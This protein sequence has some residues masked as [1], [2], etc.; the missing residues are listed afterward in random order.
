M[1]KVP[2]VLTDGILLYETF[3]G[4]RDGNFIDSSRM[5]WLETMKAA[6]DYTKVTPTVYSFKFFDSMIGTVI[7]ASIFNHAIRPESS[8]LEFYGSSNKNKKLYPITRA[9]E[10]IIL[11]YYF[12][13]TL[14][15]IQQLSIPPT[16]NDNGK[17]GF[18]KL[19]FNENYLA[20]KI[21]NIQDLRT[22]QFCFHQNKV[23]IL[24]ECNFNNKSIIL[25]PFFNK[26]YKNSY[27]GWEDEEFVEG[28][29]IPISMRELYTAFKMRD[30]DGNQ[31]S[32]EKYEELKAE[33][34]R[35]PNESKD[36]GFLQDYRYWWF[37]YD[38][39]CNVV[40]SNLWSSRGNK[41]IV[42]I[43][44]QAM[45]TMETKNVIRHIII[46]KRDCPLLCKEP[47]LAVPMK[48]AIPPWY[49]KFSI[50]DPSEDV[51]P[52]T[53]PLSFY[54]G[55]KFK[56]FMMPP[57]EAW[58]F[59]QFP[60]T[61]F[62]SKLSKVVFRG[63]STNTVRIKACQ[64][65][66]PWL[67]SKITH[68]NKRDRIDKDGNITFQDIQKLRVLYTGN[69]MTQQEQSTY[70]YL[71][72]LPGN[73]FS[74]RIVWAIASK[75]VLFIPEGSTLVAANKSWCNLPKDCYI[76]IKDSLDDLEEKFKWCEAHP[77][78]CQAMSDRCY[79]FSQ[80]VLRRDSM[81][82]YVKERLLQSF[83]M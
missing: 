60:T 47:V 20:S 55:D 69:M 22:F 57:T 71:L 63:S 75:C 58:N 48:T 27:H 24:A 34:H 21:S 74:S 40:P 33:N 16:L 68:W 26:K 59:T 28:N 42:E 12:K 78:Q 18:E 29:E 44:V 6:M 49:R 83:A 8:Y 39:V 56:D 2:A 45:Q 67:D 46:N 11:Q 5:K 9:T 37:N 80:V 54:G 73:Q 10:D 7:E 32:L 36:P 41:E 77:Q 23:G 82:Q 15:V 35:Q 62:S 17:V 38:L 14:P 19:Y 81:I 51:I 30:V 31:V 72:I 61:E 65:T 13:R 25:R 52:M 79:A 53:I 1:P 64:L 70:K 66:Y 76:E 4:L 3:F 50:Y 43:L